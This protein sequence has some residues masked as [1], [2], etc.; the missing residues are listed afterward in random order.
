MRSPS[1]SGLQAG[2]MAALKTRKVPSAQTNA[3]SLLTTVQHK[4]RLNQ[5]LTCVCVWASRRRSLRCELYR[6]NTCP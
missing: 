1:R 2:T 6:R 3:A 5:S 4:T